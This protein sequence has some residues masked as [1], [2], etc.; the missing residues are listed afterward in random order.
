MIKKIFKVTLFIIV[1]R[2][3]FFIKNFFK[4]NFYRSFVDVKKYSDLIERN[5][6]VIIENYLDKK[7]CESIINVIESYYSKNKELI[8]HDKFNSE[9]RLHGAEKIDEEINKFFSNNLLIKIGS[10]CAKTP[11]SN[12]MTM[13][14]KVK[15]NQNNLGSGGGWHRDDYNFQFK[16]IL[17]LNDVTSENGPFQFIKNSNKI[18]DIVKDTVLA[19]LDIKSTRIDSEK[20]D[21]ISN[22][23]LKTI[24][25]KAGTLILVDTSLIHRGKPLI[26]GCRYAITNYY[27]PYYQVESMK[28]HFL[29]KI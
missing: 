15:Y 18:L 8:W 17:Y 12:L 14:N 24:I 20:V 10:F 4:K 11:L 6:F 7:S 27:Y 16:A 2:L 19:S 22:K 3:T 28:N 1:R 23:R 5:G 29:P 21:L 25:G 13:A 26:N 9:Y